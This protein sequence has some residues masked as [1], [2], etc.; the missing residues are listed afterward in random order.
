[1]LLLTTKTKINF[2]T[3][4]KTITKLTSSSYN[5][6]TTVNHHTNGW[7]GLLYT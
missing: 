2:T 3:Q 6:N 5:Y 4:Q 7:W 1:M